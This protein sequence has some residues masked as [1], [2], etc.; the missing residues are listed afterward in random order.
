MLDT[1]DAQV[2]I[3]KSFQ[4][5]LTRTPLIP[6]GTRGQ[7]KGVDWDVIGFQ[8]RGIEV[9]GVVYEWN[10]YVLFNPYKGFRYLTEYNGHW[11]YVTAIDSI[12]EAIVATKPKVRYQGRTYQHFQHATATTAFVLGEF[13]WQVRM[14]EPVT[15]DDYIS[16]PYMLSSETTNVE[17]NWSFA[18]YTPGL[19]IWEGFRLPGAPPPAQGIYANQPSPYEGKVRGLWMWMF[20]LL[21]G[22]VVTAIGISAM[23]K[24]QVVFD[25]SYSFSPAAPEPSFVTPVFELKGTKNIELDIKTSLSNNWAG[26]NF[27]LINDD[28]GTAYNFGKEISYYYGN[29]DGEFWSEGDTKATIAVPGIPPGHYYLRVEPEMDKA[30]GANYTSPL[31]MPATPSSPRSRPLSPR[32]AANTMPM[33]AMNYQLTLRHDVPTFALFWIVIFLLPI[34]PIIRSIQAA[35]FNTRRWQ[36]SD[37]ATGTSSSSSSDDE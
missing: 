27:A 20:L 25:K 19:E 15:A 9:D 22:L 1:S 11:N 34:P 29:E 21:I 5:Q 36:E 30:L 4:Q 37:Y 8:T 35:S 10:E 18:E 31:S 33:S 2:K 23:A 26:F 7:L 16:P 12:P 17:T 32:A 13:P 14:P 6:L 3:L 28:T 24:Q